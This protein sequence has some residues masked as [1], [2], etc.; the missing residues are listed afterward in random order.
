MLPFEIA[1]YNGSQ[2]PGDCVVYM[3]MKGQNAG[4]PSRRPFANSIVITCETPDAA[5]R[6]FNALTALHHSHVFQYYLVGS[7]I[8]FLRIWEV[9]RVFLIYEHL[10][11]SQ[12]AEQHR[13]LTKYLSLSEMLEQQVKTV[14]TLVIAYAQNMIKP[15]V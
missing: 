8:P 4:K 10:F 5:D 7:V 3:L 9:R 13:K 11:T 2:A 1:T 6:A 14:K 12:Q 15:P